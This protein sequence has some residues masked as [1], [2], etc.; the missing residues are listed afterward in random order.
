MAKLQVFNGSSEKD[1]RVCNSMQ[2]ILKNEDK[3]RYGRRT[4]TVN[5]VICIRRISR[6]LE[7]KYVGESRNTKFG[8]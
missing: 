4:D 8:I 6:H 7:I 2:A 3:R 1:F 5:F